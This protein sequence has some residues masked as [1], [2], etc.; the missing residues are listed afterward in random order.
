MVCLLGGE[1]HKLLLRVFQLLILSS[2]RR[3]DWVRSRDR[4]IYIDSQASKFMPL[5][6][7]EERLMLTLF[8]ALIGQECSG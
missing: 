8:L 3:M 7:A 6:R 1:G 5:T 2:S 4:G